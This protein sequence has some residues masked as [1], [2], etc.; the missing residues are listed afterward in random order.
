MEVIEIFEFLK[1]FG[2]VDPRF[3]TNRYG[4]GEE[5]AKEIL[6][7]G[8]EEKFFI[9]VGDKYS[10]SQLTETIIETNQYDRI[11]DKIS[12]FQRFLKGFFKNITLLDLNANHINDFVSIDCQITGEQSQKAV[13]IKSKFECSSCGTIVS[14]RNNLDDVQS[15]IFGEIQKPKRCSCGEKGISFKE[16]DSFLL[17]LFFK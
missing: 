12:E 16:I 1:E 3:F 17:K 2:E 11:K 8:S 4:I 15:L 7:K 13:K 9:N 5:M 10:L 6:E 14:I